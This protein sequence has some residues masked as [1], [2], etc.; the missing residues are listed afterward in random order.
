MKKKGQAI[1]K[2]GYK[3]KKIHI[4]ALSFKVVNCFEILKK[5]IRSEKGKK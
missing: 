5:T 4:N 3:K 2:C 1:P